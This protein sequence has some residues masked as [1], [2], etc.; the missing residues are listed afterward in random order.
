MPF[1]RLL[2]YA[3]TNCNLIVHTM[4]DANSIRCRYFIYEK[5]CSHIHTSHRASPPH[6]RLRR[7]VLHNFWLQ[8]LVHHA[9]IS[10]T[11]VFFF[12]FFTSRSSLC[13]TVV[14]FF[15]WCCFRT[16]IVAN[17]YIYIYAYIDANDKPSSKQRTDFLIN[18]QLRPHTS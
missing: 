16:N 18:T 14:Q 12:S 13:S 6:H 5:I 4:N 3:V 1:R 2:K 10:T 7:L 8:Q 15:F 17:I 11:F 9:H